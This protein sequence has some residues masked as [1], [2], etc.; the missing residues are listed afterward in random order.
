MSLDIDVSVKTNIHTAV[1]IFAIL[2]RE[3]DLFSKDSKTCPPRI[4]RVRQFMVELEKEVEDN[5]PEEVLAQKYPKSEGN[6]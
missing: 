4:Q 3:C 2:Q 1:D 5:L 6:V